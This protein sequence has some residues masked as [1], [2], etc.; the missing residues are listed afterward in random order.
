MRK[1]FKFKD[2]EIKSEN[3]SPYGWAFSSAQVA[4]L[5]GVSENIIEKR[6]L[7]FPISSGEKTCILN[8]ITGELVSAHW[9]TLGI[10]NLCNI[11]DD[12][13]SKALARWVK[14]FHEKKRFLHFSQT[15]S[16]CK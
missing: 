3:Y 13:N 9:T 14:T 11:I 8:R 6:L 12:A 15:S 1:T 4:S 10:L 2:T 5:L 16:Y 7:D